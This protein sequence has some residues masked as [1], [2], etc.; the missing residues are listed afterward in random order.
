MFNA[1]ES[2]NLPVGFEYGLT[3]CDCPFCGSAYVETQGYQ[4]R[5]GDNERGFLTLNVIAVWCYHCS[6]KGPQIEH[7]NLRHAAR[8]AIRK[9]NCRAR[10]G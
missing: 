5:M 1:E 6:G 3:V 9:W 4:R 2:A 8:W 10:N 7:T